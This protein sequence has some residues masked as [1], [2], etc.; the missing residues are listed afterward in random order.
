[1]A[2]S[3]SPMVSNMTPED[4][5]DELRARLYDIELLRNKMHAT[6]DSFRRQEHW[7][8]CRDTLLKALKTP[9]GPCASNTGSRKCLGG[10]SG[11]ETCRYSILS[12]AS[13]LNTL[14]LG[15]A[16]TTSAPGV[17]YREVQGQDN[18]SSP[19]D[20]RP[21]M[22]DLEAVR[23]ELESTKSKLLEAEENSRSLEKNTKKDASDLLRNREQFRTAYHDMANTIKKCI[24]VLTSDKGE[25]NSETRKNI[26]L[27]V[28]L[29]HY[30][31]LDKDV[32]FQLQ[33]LPMQQHSQ[34]EETNQRKALEQ[35]ALRHQ[36]GHVKTLIQMDRH[37]E[38]EETAKSVLYNRREHLGKESGETQDI[39]R[40]YCMIL[41]KGVKLDEV[42]L[43]YM[44][45]W[46]D[47]SLKNDEFRDGAGISLAQL[48]KRRDQIDES[49]IWYKK[50]A[51]RR[52][53]RLD[54]NGAANAAL[55]MLVAQKS[56]HLS[57]ESVETLKKIWEKADINISGDVLSC[58]QELGQFFV[59]VGIYKE[60][61]DVLLAVWKA[62]QKFSGDEYINRRSMTALALVSIIGQ[63]P[64]DDR[65][66]FEELYK[67]I[68][69]LA[70]VKGDKKI[71]LQYQH[72]LG[73][74]Q[75][76]RR[77][78]GDSE[79]TLKAAWEEAKAAAPEGLGENDVLTIQIGWSYGRAI[80]SQHGRDAH[81]M[82]AFRDLCLAA[83]LP[84]RQKEDFRIMAQKKDD[85]R[86]LAQTIA[87]VT[88][89]RS[90]AELLITDAEACKDEE[91]QRA[92]YTS[93]KD[94]LQS[95]WDEVSLRVDKIHEDR[96]LDA[97]TD[98]LWIGDSYGECLTYL[99]VPEK[100]ITVLTGVLNLRNKWTTNAGETETTSE[101]RKEAIDAQERL[102]LVDSGKKVTDK[103]VADDA[104]KAGQK[105]GGGAS[106]LSP[107]GNKERARSR[108]PS[109]PKP[110]PPKARKQSRNMGAVRFF[111]GVKG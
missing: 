102:K 97:L 57:S 69:D 67:S 108:S 15:F 109:Q 6:K 7:T 84:I 71:S 5:L 47:N 98:L 39:F 43:E 3:L 36:H 38:A 105:S 64:D 16:G 51:T 72:Q 19:S 46:L 79:K 37:K 12:I 18:E 88:I 76:S 32:T 11:C 65:S 78:M 104:G 81:A 95:V 28:S 48:S 4:I 27:T 26:I 96:N 93:A 77:Y 86:T 17:T 94:V 41:E 61:K 68:V 90:Y 110:R 63:L 92:T 34:N 55:E 62:L 13:Q 52:L 89:G 74:V 29:E 14:A 82:K 21:S 8:A 56:F 35:E 73:C 106:N 53:A 42:E 100:A 2:P 1:M 50:V 58:G 30:D 40:D 99:G 59:S 45:L 49:A 9:W 66:D 60:A 70:K 91:K 83:L 80:L 54:V 111:A 10:S 103:K 24:T 85:S 107:S 23:E 75:L 87:G 31:A 101:L 44:Q 33:T 25:G 20:N 22:P